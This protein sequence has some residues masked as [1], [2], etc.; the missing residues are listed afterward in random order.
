MGAIAPTGDP[1]ASDGTPILKMGV[2]QPSART[3]HEKD[4][5]DG[6]GV[7]V[8][9]GVVI[10]AAYGASPVLGDE[11][12]APGIQEATHYTPSARAGAPPAAPP[13][14]ASHAASTNARRAPRRCTTSTAR[15]RPW[16]ASCA[17]AE[18]PRACV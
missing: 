10:G 4:G 9:L 13:I 1:S 14:A 2:E 18:L 12:E 11:A 7:G 8:S 3:R 17:R 6:V 5:A 15:R 16:S